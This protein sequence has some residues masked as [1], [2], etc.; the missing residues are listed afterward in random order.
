M[1][2]LITHIYDNARYCMSA[3]DTIDAFVRDS[4]SHRRYRYHPASL[5]C[6]SPHRSSPHPHPPD[7]FPTPAPFVGTVR[8]PAHAAVRKLARVVPFAPLL[9]PDAAQIGHP[10][11]PHPPAAARRLAPPWGS[12][13]SHVKF[14]LPQIPASI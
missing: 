8:R 4:G 6:S 2:L 13:V 9:I 12:R 5:F 11:P 3:Q 10:Q 7:L 14:P 1:T